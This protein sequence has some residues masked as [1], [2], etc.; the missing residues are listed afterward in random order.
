MRAKHI[1]G[2]K[3]GVFALS[4]LILLVGLF[5]ANWFALLQH[6]TGVSYER[7][8]IT[9]ECDKV[10]GEISRKIGSL[11]SFDPGA[12]QSCKDSRRDCGN[13]VYG[14]GTGNYGQ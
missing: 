9:A 5:F 7:T 1:L 13:A 4:L 8:V 11:D 3:G 14:H 2:E 12:G 6:R 10:R